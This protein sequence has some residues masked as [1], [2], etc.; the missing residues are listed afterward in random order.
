[1]RVINVKGDRRETICLIYAKQVLKSLVIVI[2][3]ICDIKRIEGVESWICLK[4]GRRNKMVNMLFIKAYVKKMSFSEMFIHITS[5]SVLL[6][7]K[8]D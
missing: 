6:Q 4:N 2:T 3:L 8:T 1:M 5:L 7:K